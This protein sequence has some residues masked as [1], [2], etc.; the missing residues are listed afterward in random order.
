MTSALGG[1]IQG[2]YRYRTYSKEGRNPA[3]TDPLF[4]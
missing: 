1:R 3:P 2:S 4:L